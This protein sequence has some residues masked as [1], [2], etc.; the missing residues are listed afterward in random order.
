MIEKLWDIDN[1]Y[2]SFLSV[3]AQSGWKE[4]TQRYE[5]NVLFNLTSLSDKLKHN[6]Y[7]PTRPITFLYK[8]RGKLRL[9]ESYTV[10]DRIVQNCF[11]N[12]ILIPLIKP[13]LIYDNSAS[14]ENRGA[15][16]FNRRL[17]KNLKQFSHE[18]GNDGYI[19]KGDFTKWFDNLCHE[20]FYSKLR[21]FGADEDVIEFSKLLLKDHIID[22]SY[23]T[24]EQYKNCLDIP[25]NSIEYYKNN[26]PKTGD[27]FMA[28]SMG[29]GSPIAQIGGIVG[30]CIIDNFV[31]IVCG[32]KY[33]GR[34]MDDFYIIHHSKEHL[35]ELLL[36]IKEIC[37]KEHIF[38]NENKTQIIPL[39]H[40]F[41]LL[42][43]AYYINDNN[44]VISIPDNSK[45][46]VERR[47]LNKFREKLD[48]HVMT[49]FDI[50]NNYL[51]W[52]GA[53]VK[54]FG[55]TKSILVIDEYYKQ[56]FREELQ[57]E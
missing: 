33:Y 14:L 56:L 23:M 35:V 50:N 15:D 17:I 16:F 12:D 29:I 44:E 6:T 19:L 5:E 38:L 47:K 3:K 32:E 55:E 18:Y 57:Y 21:N 7:E 34:Y 49:I 25:F 39:K 37:K 24:D 4:A 31:K 20:I 8:E 1:L 51:S 53:L 36:E 13:H 45:F 48:E 26:Y 10:E 11:V 40:K 22:V 54:Q 41:V 30:G 52:R 28:K 43:T 2:K 27:K 46:S 42:K 9:I